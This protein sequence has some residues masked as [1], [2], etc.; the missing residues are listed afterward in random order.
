ILE[1][2]PFIFIVGENG[3]KFTVHNALIAYHSRPLGTI[4]N[5][6][7][8][9]AKVSCILEDV[10]EDTFVRFAQFAYTGDYLAAKPETIIEK[11]PSNAFCRD[12]KI[13]EDGS[14]SQTEPLE[15]GPSKK[16]QL[17]EQF[18]AERYL[19][20]SPP[21]GIKQEPYH[22]YSEVFLCHARVYMFAEKYN[23]ETLM[24]L[25]L[26]KLQHT[27]THYVLYEDHIADIVTLLQYSY[28]FSAS[29]QVSTNNLQLLVAQ[30]AACIF[31]QLGK[32]QHFYTALQKSSPLGKDIIK[33]LLHRME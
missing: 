7:L 32:S 29:H 24:A 17:W 11:L 8:L 10:D 21:T 3:R 9:E 1:S 18:T 31:E 4:I 33:Q 12:P 13:Q 23:V 30:Y 27:L 5:K 28:S 22:S 20:P 25:S 6:R 19:I 26:H 2:Q 14:G 15:H 16:E